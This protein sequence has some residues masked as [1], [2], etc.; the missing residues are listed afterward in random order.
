[1]DMSKTSLAIGRRNVIALGGVGILGIGYGVTRSGTIAPGSREYRPVSDKESAAM[2]PSVRDVFPDQVR[3][4]LSKFKGTV[5]AWAG[6]IRSIEIVEEKTVATVLFE[7]EHRYFDW[8]EDV[9]I[10]Q[11]RYFLSPRGEGRFRA[12]KDVYLTVLNQVKETIHPGD[13]AV[14]YGVPSEVRG[15]VIGMFPTNYVRTLK[16]ELFDDAVLDYGREYFRPDA[17]P[18]QQ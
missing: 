11:A 18:N 10:Q 12:A 14:V 4:D 6:I 13:M 17:P 1:M 9:G 8:V 7:I 15:D 2:K 5:V 16:N 3:S